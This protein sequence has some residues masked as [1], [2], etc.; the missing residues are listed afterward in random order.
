MSQSKFAAL[1]FFSLLAAACAA[2]PTHTDGQAKT[3][4]ADVRRVR[5]ITVPAM[6]VAGSHTQTLANTNYS[7]CNNGSNDG[8]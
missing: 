1:A 5:C 3:N 8:H 6:N 4:T 2:Q 7:S